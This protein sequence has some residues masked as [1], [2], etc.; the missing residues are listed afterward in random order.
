MS[1]RAHLASAC[2]VSCCRSKQLVG[3]SDAA[4]LAAQTAGFL[5]PVAHRHKV[6]GAL[7][8]GWV[9]VDPASGQRHVLKRVEARQFYCNYYERLARKT[10]EW[11]TLEAL[12]AG[13]TSVMLC[14]YDGYA[15]PDIEAAYLDDKVTFG[16][17]AVLYTM[18][19][20]PDP[21]SWPWRKHKTFAF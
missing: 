18:L 17:E 15:I 10:K 5:D 13:G 20:S 12:V 6:K 11:A 8:T 2:R 4:F 7:L 21:A 9:W 1:T 19:H 16:H 14:G 3:E